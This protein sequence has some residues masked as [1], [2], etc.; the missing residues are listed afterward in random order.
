MNIIQFLKKPHPFI[1]NLGSILVPSL[2]TFLVFAP[3]GLAQSDTFRRF[4]YA[5]F[6]E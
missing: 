4:S 2:I 3:F 6:L 1:F 5:I